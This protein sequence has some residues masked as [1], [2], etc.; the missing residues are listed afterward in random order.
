MIPIAKNQD[1]VMRDSKGRAVCDVEFEHG[2][3][4]C[5]SFIA[6]AV[7]EDDLAEVSEEELD[8]L[9]EAYPERAEES[10]FENRACAAEAYADAA[11]GH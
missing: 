3:D 9:T 10:W 2:S 5:D 8:F 1:R 6:S 7:Y 4:P 11:R